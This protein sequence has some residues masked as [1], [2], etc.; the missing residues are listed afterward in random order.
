[1]F[2]YR[3]AWHRTPERY[4]IWQSSR[5]APYPCPVLVGCSIAVDK[6]YF[7]EIGGFDTGLDIWGGEQ[8]YNNMYIHIIHMN[9][10]N[11][12]LYIIDD[13]MPYNSDTYM[14][15]KHANREKLTAEYL[16]ST[17]RHLSPF[18]YHFPLRYPPPPPGV[19]NRQKM[20]GF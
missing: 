15:I 9:N 18:F 1:M 2:H 10:D 8:V 11:N 12:D 14:C 7:N 20:A 17:Q 6:G 13:T 5:A 19:G 16:F 4:K 3:Y